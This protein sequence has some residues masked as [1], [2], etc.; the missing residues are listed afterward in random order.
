[1]HGEGKCLCDSAATLARIEDG[2][3]AVLRYSDAGYTEAATEFPVNP[4]GSTNAIA[5]L[6]DPTGRLMGMMPHP[7]AFVHY[8]QHPRWT[9]ETLPEE[10]DGLVLY[11]NAAE[12]VKRNLI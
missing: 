5:A 11:K 3:L 2:H 1:R 9:R 8:T 10:G 6:C 4:N 12:H 7:E